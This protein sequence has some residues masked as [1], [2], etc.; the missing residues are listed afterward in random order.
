M[1]INPRLAQEVDAQLKEGLRL[2]AAVN[3]PNVMIKVPA[4]RAGYAVVEG[5]LAEGVNVNVT[6]I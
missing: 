6:L 2:F 5:L 3:R 1:E 4:T